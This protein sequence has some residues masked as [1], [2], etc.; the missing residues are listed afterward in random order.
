M[1]QRYA[2]YGISYIRNFLVCILSGRKLIIIALLFSYT[3]K[4]YMQK[5]PKNLRNQISR[6]LQSND[7]S[8]N[9]KNVIFEF[10]RNY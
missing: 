6:K 1:I 9:N 3:F 7:L 5:L 2:T 8:E 4:I 10:L